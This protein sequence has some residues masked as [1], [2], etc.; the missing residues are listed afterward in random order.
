MRHCLLFVKTLTLIFVVLGAVELR[1]QD[2]VDELLEQA[3]GQAKDIEKLKKVLNEDPDP[4]VRL[5]AFDLMIKD[6][7]PTKVAIAIDAGLASA[8]RLLQAA[9][10][11]AAIMEQ[12]RL[13]LTLE[14]DDKASDEVKDRSQTYLDSYGNKLVLELNKKDPKTGTFGSGP[15]SGEVSGT[16]LTYK[17]GHGSGVLNLQDDNAVSGPVVGYSGGYTQFNATGQFR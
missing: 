2:S 5:V 1:A 10:F 7:D 4:N 12:D 14:I 9:A 8:D 15:I 16:Q 13:H 3:R 6:G 17:W 11:K